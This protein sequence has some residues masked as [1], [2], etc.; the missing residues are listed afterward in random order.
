MRIKYGMI[1]AAG[2]GK[3]MRPLTLKTPKPLLEIGGLTLLERAINLFINHG[4]EEITVNVHHFANQIEE[5]ISDLKSDVKIKIS[6]EKDLL[7]DTG[8]GVKKGAKEFKNLAV[9]AVINNVLNNNMINAPKLLSNH[10]KNDMIE[11]SDLGEKSFYDHVISKKNK[12]NSYKLLINLLI[13]IQKIKV[14]KYY[15]FEKLKIKIPKY[16]ISN[17]HKESDLFFDWY[18]KYFISNKKISNY[19]QHR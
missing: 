14:K 16:T 5:L 12:L 3:R 7:L 19:R 6:N 11:I 17:L 2:L 10:Y 15:K 13:K 18:L 4:V 1:L 9:Y 8:G